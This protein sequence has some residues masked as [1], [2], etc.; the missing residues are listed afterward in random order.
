LRRPRVFFDTGHVGFMVMG[1][2]VLISAI[3]R[4]PLGAVVHRRRR[5][6]RGAIPFALAPT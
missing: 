4:T 2:T 5:I 6:R 3:A 1:W